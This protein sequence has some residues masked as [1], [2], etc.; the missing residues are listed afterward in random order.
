MRTKPLEH[1]ILETDSI[2]VRL[3]NECDLEAVLTIDAA[4]QPRLMRSPSPL[5]TRKLAWARPGSRIC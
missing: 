1:G 3:M 4:G 2:L 5:H